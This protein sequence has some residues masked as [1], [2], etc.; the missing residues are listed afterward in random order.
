[1]SYVD[2]FMRVV[3][4]AILGGLVGLEREIH[5]CA[6]G[7]RTHIL[8]SMGSAVFMVT[9]LLVA[10]E[11]ASVSGTDPARIAANVVTGIGFLGAGAIIRYGASIRGLTTAA[12]I[13]AVAAVGLAAGGGFYMMAVL[14]SV[15]IIGTLFLSRLE[16][17]MELKRR[18]RKLVVKFDAKAGG[19]KEDI[20]NIIEAYSGRVKQSASR[21][22][23]EGEVIFS[24]DL[25]LSRLYR[26]DVVEEV[27]SLPG[28]KSVYWE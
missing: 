6:A 2:M 16:V 12:S 18:G 22:G 28:I 5:G 23:G 7:L 13:W 3:V 4:S 21:E 10:M 20:E 8:V 9:S 15:I 17:K 27:A 25:I 24:F 11:Y 26:D 19:S 1:M 14:A